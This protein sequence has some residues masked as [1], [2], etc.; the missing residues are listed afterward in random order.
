MSMLDGWQYVDSHTI[1]ALDESIVRQRYFRSSGRAGDDAAAKELRALHGALVRE[2]YDPVLLSV[3]YVDRIV[4]GGRVMWYIYEAG[5]TILSGHNPDLLYVMPA[6]ARLDIVRGV[7]G[8]EATEQLVT[9]MFYYPFNS[10]PAFIMFCSINGIKEPDVLRYFYKWRTDGARS[11]WYHVLHS[12]F[13]FQEH[14]H[15]VSMDETPDLLLRSIKIAR[16]RILEAPMIED[17]QRE[18]ERLISARRPDPQRT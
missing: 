5:R 1:K 13:P 14:T 11:V 18:L 3:A 7:L 10:L 2:H 6:P 12:A 8:D 4:P 9:D 17:W 16:S 15:V